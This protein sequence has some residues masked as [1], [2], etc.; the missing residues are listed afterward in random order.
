MVLDVGK[1]EVSFFM[2]VVYA[3][4]VAAESGIILSGNI[5]GYVLTIQT[6]FDFVSYN[7]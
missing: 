7:L 1:R 3:G 4:S 6:Y 2:W 5:S